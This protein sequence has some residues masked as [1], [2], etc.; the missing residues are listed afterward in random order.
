MNLNESTKVVTLV[1]ELWP[2]FVS[3]K[4]TP[5]A[6]QLMFEDEQAMDVFQAI[7]QIAKEEPSAFAPNVSEVLCKVNAIR[8]A[9]KP[10]QKM[11]PSN[12]DKICLETYTIERE[13]KDAKGQMRTVKRTYTR[14]SKGARAA[15]LEVYAKQKA[16]RK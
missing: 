12:D 7:K 4:D 14:A 13:E 8:A 9:R 1:A 11:L 3:T 15:I 16:N 5:R 6:W 2:N 10:A